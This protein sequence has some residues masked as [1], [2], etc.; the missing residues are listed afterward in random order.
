M[1][2]EHDNRIPPVF[3]VGVGRYGLT[4]GDRKCLPEIGSSQTA[5]QP[6]AKLSTK[7]DP[8]ATA[9]AEVALFEM[10]KG[11]QAQGMR[12]FEIVKATAIS[13]GRLDKWQRLDE[14]RHRERWCHG[15]EWAESF[16]EELRQRWNQGCQNGKHLFAEMR[17]RGYVGSYTGLLRLLAEWRPEKTAVVQA[18]N[19]TPQV[20]AMRHVSL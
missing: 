18:I 1:S 20:V 19:S 9:S 6:A 15:P 17:Q 2:V 11:R 14:C 16:R 8:A 3:R 4:S 5:A 10:V 7:G 13:H 12:A